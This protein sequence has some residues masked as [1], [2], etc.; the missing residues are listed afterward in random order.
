MADED[1]SAQHPDNKKFS[2]EGWQDLDKKKRHCTDVLCILM[3]LA[4]WFTM[5]IIGLIVVGAIH[6]DRLRA[7][8]PNRLLHAI[9][10]DGR[11]CGLDAGVRDRPN[12]YYMTSS[13]VVCVEDCPG[14]TNLNKFICFDERQEE[15]DANTEKA[16][17]FVGRQE[18]L[19]KTKTQ[20]LVNRCFP[21]PLD[22]NTSDWA[23]TEGGKYGLD[24]DAIPLEYSSDAQSYLTSF[25][26]TMWYLRGYI[27]GFGLGISVLV[28][29]IYLYLLR[30]P[31]LLFWI[32]WSI[33]LSVFALLLVGALL[34]REKA[35]DWQDD[36]DRTKSEVTSMFVI[37]YILLAICGLYLCFL[38]VMRK[39][40]N[41]AIGIVKEAARALAAMP[42]I[43]ALPLV[44]VT[45]L[46]LFLIP[47]VAYVIFLASSGDVKTYESDTDSS[48]KYRTF[49]YDNN[50]KYAFLYLLF[51]Y[52]WT[53]EFIIAIGQIT[54]AASFAGWY[55]T[56][57]KS[58]LMNSKVIWA[59]KTVLWY[60]CGTAAFGSLLIAI[61][62]T[63]QAVIKYLQKKAKKSK[64][65]LAKVL[66]FILSCLSCC[67]W[68]MEKCMKF[69]N[70]NGYIQTAIHGYSF[71][72][73]CRAAFFLLLRNILR[74]L[75]VK[76]VGDFVLLLGK[77]L[78][79]VST[80]FLC[81]LAI[82]YGISD[83]EVPAIVA[84]LIF[85]LI[86]SYFIACMFCEIFGMGI[87]TIMHCFIADE[88]M[89]EPDKRFAENGLR[90]TWQKTNIAST[91]NKVAPSNEADAQK[92]NKQLAS[93]T[94]PAEGGDKPLL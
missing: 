27:F 88:E 62:K 4:C 81:Y 10:Y 15:A 70:K 64:N 29:F 34:L 42:M 16:W 40:I 21:L 24:T 86:L 80:V 14:S 3:I 33:L 74:V 44:Q 59:G 39:R 26:I 18:C 76:L 8:N 31:G 83:S 69:I 77:L 91:D 50:T 6:D 38:V 45:G 47:W 65:R 52:F 28:A 13:A 53:S 54:V 23:M 58:V 78:I 5:T 7:G 49:E 48:V 43:L 30:I 68:C 22:K 17:E 61:L 41:L 84:P 67:I 37:S 12:A 2:G 79:P 89:F 32:I 11:I 60:H 36:D 93:A 71:C 9:D 51:A 20:E 55:F 19:F 57:E 66:S 82:G 94:P 56:R 85:V 72:K 46:L 92:D 35:M 87:T 73:A 1:K 25:F 63:I 90:T 75:G